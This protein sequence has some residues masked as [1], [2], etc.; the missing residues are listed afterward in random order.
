MEKEAIQTAA[1]NGKPSASTTVDILLADIQPSRLLPQKHR[2]ERFVKTGL[3]ELAVS[4]TQK[5]VI[6]PI[7]VRPL[8]KGGYELVAGERR[9]LAS[10]IA[11]TTTITS[12][13]RELSDQ[14]AAEIQ[15]LEN[16]QREDIHPLDEAISYKYL[17]EKLKLSTAE[18]ALRVGKTEKHVLGRLK[19]NFLTSAALK[20]LNAGE[21]PIGHAM[22]LAKYPDDTQKIILKECLKP[23]SWSDHI[24]NLK[25]FRDSIERQVQLKLSKAPFSL[26][27]TNLLESGLACVDCPERTGANPTLFDEADPK[28]DRCL[29]K[30]CYEKKVTLFIQITRTLVTEAAIRA[31]KPADYEAPLVRPSGYGKDS[32]YP[33]SL[34]YYDAKFFTAKKD[35]C[36][37]AETGVI[38]DKDRAG[39]KTFFCRNP[40]CKKHKQSSSYSSSST[41]EKTDAERGKFRQRKEEIWNIK[42]REAVRRTVLSQAAIAFSQTFSASGKKVDLLPGLVARMWDLCEGDTLLKLVKPLIAEMMVGDRDVYSHEL[43]ERTANVRDKFTGIEQAQ[44]LFLLIHGA[45]SSMYDSYRYRA[46]GYVQDLADEFGINYRLIDAKQRVDMSPKKHLKAHA[47]YLEAVGGGDSK[48][49]IP[50]LY[51]EKYTI[52]DRVER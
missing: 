47:A 21:L 24:N 32:R 2:R 3:N 39:Q 35:T 29:N 49:K 5:G 36:E 7:T 1:S 45:E 9:W 37:F 33:K 41:G 22:E 30:G 11:E 23:Y 15:L 50:L 6:N 16:L 42:V 4:I 27:A 38:V 12:V 52:Q 14:D 25:D 40:K 31:G 10:K 17:T 43:T 18:I 26:K 51:A 34:G 8:A 48:V 19:L 13:V 46:Q 20:M 28:D 44:V